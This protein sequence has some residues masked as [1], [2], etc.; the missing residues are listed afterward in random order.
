M[1][2]RRDRSPA[3]TPRPPPARRSVSPGVFAASRASCIRAARD[4]RWIPRGAIP[5]CAAAADSCPRYSSL[6]NVDRN[7]SS[8]MGKESAYFLIHSA[9]AFAADLASFVAP[10]FVFVTLDVADLL[11]HAGAEGLLLIGERDADIVPLAL[12]M[13]PHHAARD[14]H[15]LLDDGDADDDAC[16]G[17]HRLARAKRESSHADIVQYI[18]LKR[19]V[20]IHDLDFER[21][22]GRVTDVLAHRPSFPVIHCFQY[23]T[24]YAGGR[25]LD[26]A[27]SL[28]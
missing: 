20:L 24:A 16:T 12:A 14:L 11:H 22:A 27:A 2:K 18:L 21:D 8:S 17:V 5:V 4:R 28:N 6:F 19:S 7:Y 9:A 13:A 3:C 25:D 23:N 15:G 1:R 10:H 26:G